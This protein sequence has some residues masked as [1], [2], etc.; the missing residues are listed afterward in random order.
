MNLFVCY[1]MLVYITKNYKKVHCVILFYLLF[2]FFFYTLPVQINVNDRK[3]FIFFILRQTSKTDTENESQILTEDCS[4]S[5]QSI[6][7][8]TNVFCGSGTH[9]LLK[10]FFY[11]VSFH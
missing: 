5:T 9:A 1:V 3:S 4:L 8:G 10:M 2:L 6:L 7:P 11:F